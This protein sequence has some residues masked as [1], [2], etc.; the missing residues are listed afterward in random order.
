MRGAVIVEVMEFADRHA[1]H[2]PRPL[3]EQQQGLERRED[4]WRG[5]RLFERVPEHPDLLVV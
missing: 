3:A 4:T 5:L 1:G 2:F